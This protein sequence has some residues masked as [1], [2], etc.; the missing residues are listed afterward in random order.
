MLTAR[1]PKFKRDDAVERFLMFRLERIDNFKS[2]RVLL[3]DIQDRRNE[4][5]SELFNHLKLCIRMNYPPTSWRDLGIP[6][7]ENI[8]WPNIR[9]LPRM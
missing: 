3:G 6:I 9:L 5:L 4:I 1:T 7:L 2:E 8:P